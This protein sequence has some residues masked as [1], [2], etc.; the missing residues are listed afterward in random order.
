MEPLVITL[1]L[2]YPLAEPAVRYYDNAVIK[3]RIFLACIAIVSM[4]LV[5]T[6]YMPARADDGSIYLMICPGGKAQIG[7]T[8]ADHSIMD[9]ANM[10]HGDQG[11]AS[12]TSHDHHDAQS[13]DM[14][15]DYAGGSLMPLA[16]APK[17]ADFEPVWMP[18]RP[19]SA[20][21]LTGI[22]PQGLPPATGPP[23][24]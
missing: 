20:A 19:F 1:Y 24:F 2:I 22:F 16:D 3:L 12:M 11:A 4:G 7:E 10:D 13:F 8:A 14:R 9:H 18:K 23:V 15:C 17:I 6:G 21:L 5:P